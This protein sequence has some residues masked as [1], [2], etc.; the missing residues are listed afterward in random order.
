MGALL[1]VSAIG[2]SCPVKGASAEDCR[3]FDRECMDAKTAGYVDVGICNVERLEC[4]ADRDVNARRQPSL[5]PLHDEAR[6]AERAHGERS[7][8]P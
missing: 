8:G 7:V 4:P 6:D 1:F 2:D 5:E 3:E